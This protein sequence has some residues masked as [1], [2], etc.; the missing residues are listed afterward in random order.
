[1]KGPVV[2]V[3]GGRRAEGECEVHRWEGREEQWK[4]LCLVALSAAP[5]INLTE[6]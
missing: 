1:M 6:N 2:Q 4:E 3:V 5:E